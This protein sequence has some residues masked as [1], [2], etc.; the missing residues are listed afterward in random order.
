MVLRVPMHRLDP[1]PQFLLWLDS[2][3]ASDKCGVAHL[4]LLSLTHRSFT[5]LESLH[6]YSQDR[7]TQCEFRY[8]SISKGSATGQNP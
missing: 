4:L 8:L 3:V 2:F 6:L 1:L 7:V 5:V